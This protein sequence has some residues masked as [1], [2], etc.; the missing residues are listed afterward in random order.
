M[1]QAFEKYISRRILKKRLIMIFSTALFLAGA[2]LCY[3]LLEAT[4]QIRS[5][6]IGNSEHFYEHT[7]YQKPYTSAL[8][9]CI[10]LAATSFVI[11]IRDLML[12]RFKSLQKGDQWITVYRGFIYNIVYV[13]FAEK[14]RTV[15]L[16]RVN[17]INVWL[18][19]RVRATVHFSHSACNVAHISFSDHTATIDL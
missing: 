19:D 6:P 14:G 4:K 18:K 7:V 5:V 1:Q 12:C 2:I 3:H 10:V 13:D 11:L 8:I 15:H 16:P 9:I 17:V